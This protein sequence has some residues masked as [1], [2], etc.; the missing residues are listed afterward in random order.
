[1]GLTFD[2]QVV[3][4]LPNRFTNSQEMRNYLFS[5]IYSPEH[6]FAD[7]GEHYFGFTGLNDQ[8]EII[9]SSEIVL[10][11]WRD[12]K[13]DEV[14]DKIKNAR[15]LFLEFKGVARELAQIL[16]G[17]L[18]DANPEVERLYRRLD[19]LRKQILAAYPEIFDSWEIT[20]SIRW[21]FPKNKIYVDKNMGPL[22]SLIGIATPHIQWQSN[23][24][25]RKLPGNISYKTTFPNALN[26]S[27]KTVPA[28]YCASP[29]RMQALGTVA[30]NQMNSIPVQLVTHK[31]VQLF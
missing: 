14:Q 9:P 30:G 17:D 12:G 8:P 13:C 3:E 16:G 7:I 26:F 19:E 18:A 24:P 2:R 10:L 27:V 1:V 15:G 4:R 25:K 11:N 21:E 31:A 5:V 22:F 20:V 28:E 6:K 29:F 23:D